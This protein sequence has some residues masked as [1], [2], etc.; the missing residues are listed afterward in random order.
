M[1]NYYDRLL[2]GQY[3]SGC[4]FE[5]DGE[6]VQPREDWPPCIPGVA[7]RAREAQAMALYRGDL[8][9]GV[10][11]W[12][13]LWRYDRNAKQ[14]SAIGRMFT[15]PPVTDKVV[16]PFEAEIVAYNAA[17]GK[18]NVINDWGQRLTSL[19][20][21]GDTMYAGTSNKG[22]TPRPAD[23]TF[24]DDEILK[25]Y[26]QVL[27]LRRPGHLCGQVQWAKGPTTFQ[28]LVADGQMRLVQDGREL[29]SA[30]LDRCLAAGLKDAK[31]AWGSGMFGPLE[32]KIT[33][34]SAD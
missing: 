33:A 13:E 27:R 11:P 1:L 18:N 32:G 24:I 31:I 10:W 26:G 5:F 15:R 7:K 19:A 21:A 8:Y 22:G 12:A 2:L 4:L 23:Y 30:P 29:A 17:H 9:A 28:F 3:P 25:E 14:W 34:T 20:V 6:E 16:H